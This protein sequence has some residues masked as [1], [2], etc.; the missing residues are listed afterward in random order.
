VDEERSTIIIYENGWLGW[1]LDVIRLFKLNTLITSICFNLTETSNRLI[2]CLTHYQEGRHQLHLRLSVAVHPSI[3]TALF[4]D[5]G[6][7]VMFNS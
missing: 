1:F 3:D 4:D 7:V 6:A 2:D 5:K